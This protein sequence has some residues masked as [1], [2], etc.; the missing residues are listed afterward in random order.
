MASNG[1]STVPDSH[2]IAVFTSFGLHTAVAFGLIIAFS[3]LRPTNKIVYQPKLK[4]APESKRPKPLSAAPTAWIQPIISSNESRIVNQLGLDAVMFLRFLKFLMKLFFILTIFGESSFEVTKE[5]WEIK[6]GGSLW[7]WGGGLAGHYR[8]PAISINYYFPKITGQRAYDG[9]VS[10]LD[11][12]NAAGFFSGGGSGGG[13]GSGSGSTA[14]G[15]FNTIS[16]S[17]TRLTVPASSVTDVATATAA[18]TSSA[19]ASASVA[20]STAEASATSAALTA[21]PG[22]VVASSTADPGVPVAS[23]TAAVPV[24]GLNAVAFKVSRVG[25]VG[26]RG[27]LD[28]GML[29]M[30]LSRRQNSNVSI[31]GFNIPNP[32]LSKFTLTQIDANSPWFWMP[33][34]L[35]WLFSFITYFMLWRVWQDYIAFRKEWFLS[36]EFQKAFYNRALLLINVPESL[37]SNDQLLGF[38]SSLGLKYPPSQAVVNRELGE[39]PKLI[40]KHEATTK[41]LEAV[42]AKYLDDPNNLPAQ[43]PMMKAADGSQVDAISYLGG[44]IRQLEDEIYAL[45]ARPESECKPNSSAFVS[46]DTIKAAHSAGRKLRENPA[47]MTISGKVITPPTVKLSPPLEEIIWDNIGIPLAARLP[48]RLIALGLTIGLTI[49]WTFFV[50]AVGSLSDLTT[51]FRSN[52]GALNWLIDP[53]HQAFV[54]FL[55]GFLAPFVMAVA[56]ILLPIALRIITKVQGVTSTHGVEKSVLYKF[57]V[58]QVYQVFVFAIYIGVTKAYQS[59]AQ[60]SNPPGTVLDSTKYAISQAVSGVANNSNFYITLLA[61]YFAGYGIEIIQGVPL[62]MNF[63]KRRFFKLTP[64]DKFALNQPPEFNFTLIYGSLCIVFVIAM[65]FA[66]IA[67]MI[68]PFALLF[69]CLAYVVMKYQF[70][71]VYEVRRETGGTWWPKVFN[72]VAIGV[73]FFQVM[74]LVVIFVALQNSNGG[75]KKAKVAAVVP[76]PFL[77]AALWFYVYRFLSPKAAYVSKRDGFD[78][79]M[80]EGKSPAGTPS[81]ISPHLQ[82]RKAEDVPLEDQAFNPA[83]VRPLMKVWVWKRSE[84]LLPALY[85][86]KYASFTQYLQA[87]PHAVRA[88]PAGQ[89]HRFR[90]LVKGDHASLSRDRAMRRERA[91]ALGGGVHKEADVGRS[92]VTSTVHLVVDEAEDEIPPEQVAAEQEEGIVE[93]GQAF[94]GSSMSIVGER[95]GRGQSYEMG[96]M[97]G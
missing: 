81:A 3:V 94:G 76:L 32:D 61:T 47:I 66:T 57:F 68:L 97:R 51:M 44:E 78:G 87:N 29:D 36:E 34:G 10:S 39:L 18:P 30:H 49:A 82:S 65:A 71:Y 50:A 88:L 6:G 19:A 15:V 17:R 77:T 26:V 31:A 55:Q 1:T 62:L 91:E 86:P 58:F 80:E 96:H 41:K 67:P 63:A 48:R 74:S 11:D 64:R 95:G 60:D 4:F 38:M 40:S 59:L 75:D 54:V 14:T 27:E 93:A 90:L 83:L 23:S 35:T 24:G 2:L 53:K 12:G 73:G 70:M 20:S 72:L 84:H 22:T 56:N 42:L 85:M 16:A 8:I 52:P 25:G 89:R 21:D 79:G 46:F 13:S 69:F 92:Q 37:H 5:V 43:R 7:T 45:R 33:V 28:A 9:T